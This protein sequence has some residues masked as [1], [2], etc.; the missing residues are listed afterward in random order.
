MKEQQPS[1][2]EDPRIIESPGDSQ[3]GSSYDSYVDGLTGVPP[4]SDESVRAYNIYMRH[5]SKDASDLFITLLGGPKERGFDNAAEE[6]MAEGLWTLLSGGARFRR[7]L[8][9][10][11]ADTLKGRDA[12]YNRSFARRLI[13]F[14]RKQGNL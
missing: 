1:E 6:L 3:G 14:W 8:Q 5:H 13:A 10:E 7:P 2:G 11:V 4:P 12:M 9:Q